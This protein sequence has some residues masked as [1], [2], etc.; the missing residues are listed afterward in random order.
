MVTIAG[1]PAAAVDAG[2]TMEGPHFA[3][4]GEVAAINAAIDSARA[5]G[6]QLT[7]IVPVKRDL[8]AVLSELEEPSR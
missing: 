7:S 5:H 1:N 8:E 2:F 3:F 6:L 4:E